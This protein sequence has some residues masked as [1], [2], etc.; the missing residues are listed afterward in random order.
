[1]HHAPIS[2]F[3]IFLLATHRI[4]PHALFREVF[5]SFRK[6]VKIFGI[7]LVCAPKGGYGGEKSGF[8]EGNI[9]SANYSPGILGIFPEN[10]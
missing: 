3:P 5:P 10:R 2:G 6:H 7:N 9:P 1:M 4:L 8:T